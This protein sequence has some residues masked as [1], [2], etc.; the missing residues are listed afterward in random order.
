MRGI[1]FPKTNLKQTARYGLFSFFY[2]PVTN[3]RCCDNKEAVTTFI[4]IDITE[5][6]TMEI[7]S[8]IG[9]KVML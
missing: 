4:L 3:S 8:H 1:S 7:L 9:H 5:V 2:V 6:N